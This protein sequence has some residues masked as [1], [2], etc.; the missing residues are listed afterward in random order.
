MKGL[1]FGFGEVEKMEG[2]EEEAV[3]GFTA[4][5]AEASIRGWCWACGG[6]GKWDLMLMGVEVEKVKITWRC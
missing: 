2:V 4:M 5:A 3:V 6:K 1:G